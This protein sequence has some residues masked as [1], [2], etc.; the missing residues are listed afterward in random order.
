M[1]RT[2]FFFPLQFCFDECS[3]EVPKKHNRG[4]AGVSFRVRSESNILFVISIKGELSHFS[5]TLQVEAFAFPAL[6][7]LVKSGAISTR[8][9]DQQRVAVVTGANKG[10]GLEVSRILGRVPGIVCVMGCRNEQAPC[11]SVSSSLINT[12]AVAPTHF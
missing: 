5:S 9:S 6:R 11:K 10:I 4:V 3:E 8:M 12:F 2:Q 7:G 1:G